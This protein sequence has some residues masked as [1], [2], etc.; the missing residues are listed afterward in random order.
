MSAEHSRVVHVFNQL[1]PG[2][3]ELRTVD[4]VNATGLAFDFLCVAGGQ[5]SLDA[6][7]RANGHNVFNIQLNFRSLQRYYR[8]L[9][10]GN[11]RAIHSH[12]GP[13][14]GILLVVAILAGI[15]RRITHFRSD[16]VGGHSRLAKRLY[17][18]I[19]R[20]AVHV[21]STQILGVSPG[22]LEHGWRKNWRSDKRCRVIPNGYDVVAMRNRVSHA[23]PRQPND[24]LRLVNVARP[25]PEK[26]RVRAVEI[27]LE[28]TSIFPV[29][30][31]LVG[32]LSSAEQ[33]FCA[34]ARQSALEPSNLSLLG[35]TSEA[36]EEIGRSDVLLV[37][38]SREGLPGVVLEALALGVPVVSSDLSGS[39]WISE[40]VTGISICKL[41][42]DNTTWIRAIGDARSVPSADIRSSFDE[43]P[44]NQERVLPQFMEVW[45]LDATR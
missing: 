3:A 36:I 26:N 17:L 9:R 20:I 1:N 34:A 39:Q 37:T 8:F 19:S 42:D 4:L 28:A 45:G 14:S 7:L 32:D 13:A 23:P 41:T 25:L 2:G 43:S 16:G 31:T 27:W 24:V 30:L 35:F 29:N 10:D 6:G 22:A 11:Y 40:H 44:F 5:G 12:L 18:L 38:S 15:P 21:C 33:A